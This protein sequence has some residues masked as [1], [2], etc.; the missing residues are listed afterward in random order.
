V[1]TAHPLLPTNGE[2]RCREQQNGLPPLAGE[3]GPKGRMR[4]RTRQ[5]AVA[6]QRLAGRAFAKSNGLLRVAPL[7]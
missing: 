7:I 1:A 2:V 3:G 5:K 6:V 4:G